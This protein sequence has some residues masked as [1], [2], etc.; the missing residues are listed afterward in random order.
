[1]KTKEHKQ[2][3]TQKDGRRLYEADRAQFMADPKLRK[4]Y[5][6]EA[7]KKEIWLQLTEARQAAGLTQE[8]LA[9][10][11]GVTQSQVSKMEKRGYENYTLRSLQRYIQALGD[12]LALDVSIHR[13]KSQ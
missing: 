11:L 13:L 4:I 6:E 2:R 7:H 12:D 3:Y 9:A 8:D 1:M 10:R 5:E